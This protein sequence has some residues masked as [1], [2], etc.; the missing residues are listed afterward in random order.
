MTTPVSSVHTKVRAALL[1]YEA[2]INPVQ[3]V[4]QPT[5]I[6]AGT[7]HKRAILAEYKATY[8]T[9]PDSIITRKKVS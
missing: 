2:S 4:S 7:K 5:V 6:V 8:K 3:Q 1:A 9:G